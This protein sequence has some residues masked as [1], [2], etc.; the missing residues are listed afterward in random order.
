M[1]DKIS[2]DSAEHVHLKKKNSH[3]WLPSLRYRKY[4][5]LG[6][7]QVF[8]ETFLSIALQRLNGYIPV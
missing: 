6:K 5:F 2:L 1:Y 7:R 3:V 8:L 4:V